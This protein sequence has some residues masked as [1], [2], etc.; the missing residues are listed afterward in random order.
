MNEYH[1]ITISSFNIANFVGYLNNFVGNIK[2]DASMTQ[3]GQVE[4]VLMDDEIWKNNPDFV[5][6]WTLPEMVSSTFSKLMDYEIVDKEQ[7]FREI[8]LYCQLISKIIKFVKK[9]IFIPSWVVPS[10]YQW[11]GMLDMKDKIGISNML[12][13]MNLRLSKNLENESNVYILNTQKWIEIVGSNK[14]F[15]HKMWYLGKI[16][17]GNE[18]FKEAAKDI[19]SDLN[20]IEGKAK[21][22]LIVDLDETLWGGVIGDIGMNNLILG[23]H[24]PIGEA[25][26]D[27]QKSLKALTNKGI[28]LGI[29]SKNEE[30]I[31]VE[32][33]EKH[34]EM[35]L[36]L[37]DFSGWRINWQD[38]AY[39]IR[40]LAE[41]LNIGLQS[42]VFI[43]DNPA[44]RALI[45]DLLPEV[46]VP[47]WPKDK[48][49]Y[50]KSLNEL[51]CF[52]NPRIS[53]EDAE[54][55]KMY[56]EENKRKETKIEIS[57][58]E[59]WL[60]TLETVVVVEGL[61]DSNK[62]RIIQLL[63]K[64]NQM[65]LSTR[66]ITEN[67]LLI[68][69]SEGKRKLWAFRVS[70]KFGASGLTG[71]ISLDINDDNAGQV[72]DFILSCRV[73]GRKIEE[74]MV[75]FVLEY[76]QKIGLTKIYARYLPTVKNKPCFEFW[77]INSGFRQEKDMFEFE[78]TK[79]YSLPDCIKLVN[80]NF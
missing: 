13:Q 16:P 47:E 52:N 66:R 74:T 28:L 10:S 11:L 60:K 19:V 46:L 41:E 38:K 32:A 70:D 59:D 3:Y 22:L 78:M 44:E 17:F 50:K 26:V 79:K 43:D 36:R 34:P 62:N 61:N 20:G 72:I 29:V 33:L 5:I 1:G 4:S 77:K 53:K 40:A 80:K 57:N 35:I 51:D 37:K 67:E 56:K 65:N 30:S 49:L 69:L 45:R 21:K 39:N 55:T 64:T 68:W 27:F 58:V 25:F 48:L 14:A 12:M 9:A 75:Y 23:G 2:I 76:A 54:R 31:A 71:I 42:I 7:I 8:D 6:I 73:M 18:V 24:D 63:N 15:N